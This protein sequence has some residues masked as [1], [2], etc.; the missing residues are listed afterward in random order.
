MKPKVI[1][2]NTVQNFHRKCLWQI[3]GF[4][5]SEFS[6][7][8]LLFLNCVALRQDMIWIFNQNFF[9]LLNFFTLVRWKIGFYFF[10]EKRWIISRR[11]KLVYQFLETFLGWK[12]VHV[13]PH[14]INEIQELLIVH[15]IQTDWFIQALNIL[16]CNL[17]RPV[18]AHF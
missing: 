8:Y 6:W 18:S 4:W 13:N 5:R 11:L 16:F 17:Y 14:L 2:N 9:K 15:L 1:T 12:L 7:F 3:C 10:L